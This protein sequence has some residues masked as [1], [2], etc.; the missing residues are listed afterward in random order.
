MSRRATDTVGSIDRE[1]IVRPIERPPQTT[2]QQ[3]DTDR[4]RSTGEG[5]RR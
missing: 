1:T 3:T 4:Q 2:V 5:A